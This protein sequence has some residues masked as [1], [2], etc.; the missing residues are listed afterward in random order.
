MDFQKKLNEITQRWDTTLGEGLPQLPNTI[1][2][3]REVARPI[4]DGHAREHFT[5][6]YW[7]PIYL[8]DHSRRFII[9]GRQIRKSAFTTDDIGFNT[10]KTGVTGKQYAYVTFDE[11]SKAGY[12]KQKL[13][14]GMFEQ[15]QLLR[16]FPRHKLGNVSIGEISLLNGNT[17]YLMTDHGEYK[18]LEGKSIDHAYLDEAQYQTI[19]HYGKIIQTMM[20]TKGRITILGI[21]GEAGSPYE[22]LW[23]DTDQREWIYDDPLWREKLRFG[24][25]NL[26]PGEF[27]LPSSGKLIIG[28]YLKEILRGHWEAK[29]PDNYMFHGYHIPQTIV[30][31][32]PLT[33]WS[34]INEYG[35][36]PIFSIEWQQK[37]QSAQFVLTHVMGG[38]FKSMRRP[39]TSEMVLN[40]MKPYRQ[41]GLIEPWEIADIKKTYQD[42]VKI[43]M[44]IDWGSGNPSRTV[45]SV[46]I[47][48]FIKGYPSRIQLA[49]CEAREPENQ[50]DQAQ[51]ATT[52]FKESRCDVGVGDLG[53]GANQVKIMQDGGRDRNTGAWFEGI[54]AD[55]FVGARAKRDESRRL[56]EQTASA[57]EHGDIRPKIMYDNSSVINEFVDFLEQKVPHP[58]H[59]LRKEWMRQRFIIPYH[60]DEPERTEW[61]IKELTKLTRKDIAE[62]PEDTKQDDKELVRIQYKHPPDALMSFIYAKIA[63][64][65]KPGINWFNV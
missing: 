10:T 4:V 8:D 21:G 22:A 24:E 55:K 6:P 58:L 42:D 27:M 56:K 41:L 45:I 15:N 5:T 26:K 33:I 18:H 11:L 38:F 63:L 51:W 44:G 30:A 12:S 64:Q 57:D 31:T 34:A 16:M 60:V 52:V 40:C 19:E 39:I 47:E 49:F 23:K 17:I 29:A 25:V 2:K 1:M 62:K 36:D 9:G 43:A 50:M 28:E 59:P 37:Y 54:G 32:I 53:Y 13:Q 14:I 61:I 35:V 20:A 65:I 7:D 46:F 3:W 48:W